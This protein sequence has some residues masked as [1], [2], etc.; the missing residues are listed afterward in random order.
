MQ[1]NRCISAA[2]IRAA[3]LLLELEIHLS[4]I[5]PLKRSPRLSLAAGLKPRPSNPLNADAAIAK[6]LTNLLACH[7]GSENESRPG[8]PRARRLRSSRGRLRPPT[9][10]GWGG[11]L[12]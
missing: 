4:F 3:N 11:R 7:P 9:R 2:S 6:H 1:T 12:L 10:D 5:L 8:R